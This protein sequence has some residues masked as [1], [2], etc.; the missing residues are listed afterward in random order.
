MEDN[1]ITKYLPLV[2]SGIALLLGLSNR[3]KVLSLETRCK[4]S[5]IAIAEELDKVDT[6]KSSVADNFKI[7]QKD[8]NKISNFVGFKGRLGVNE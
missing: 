8:V 7:L 3:N 2:A 5:F 4:G 6:F 1:N